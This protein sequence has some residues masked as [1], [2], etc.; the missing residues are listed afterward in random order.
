M[1]QR[2]LFLS[3]SFV[4]LCLAI[5]AYILYGVCESLHSTQ[6]EPVAKQDQNAA[7]DAKYDVPTGQA[8]KP[9]SHGEAKDCRS[10]PEWWLVFVTV[11]L[12]AFTL[13]LM[14]YT[15]LL[16]GSTKKLMEEASAAEAPFVIPGDVHGEG[17]FGGD[18]Q[19]PRLIYNFKNHG[20]SPAIIRRWRD[21]SLFT[22]AL[23]PAPKF[24]EEWSVR[25]EKY[26]PVPAGESGGAI[27]AHAPNGITCSQISEGM[28]NRNFWFYVIGEVEY[29]D[30]FGILRI[31]GYCLRI[32]HVREDKEGL[33]IGLDRVSVMRDGGRAYNTR[34]N[35]N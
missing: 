23:P 16:W 4:A 15:A 9:Q 24:N 35:V 20:K 2:A 10:N 17:F 1:K 34:R 8:V 21:Y 11:A 27:A 6:K 26:I 19:R 12:V 29:E 32:S 30:V 13:G 25:P 7:K 33:G 14:I 28:K 22:D 3:L 5:P 31:Q 18:S